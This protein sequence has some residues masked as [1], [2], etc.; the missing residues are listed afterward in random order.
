ML[1]RDALLYL[2]SLYNEMLEA[3]S[4]PFQWREYFVII[5]FMP[6]KR[7]DFRQI[8][9]ASNFLKILEKIVQRRLN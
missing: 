7:D 3:G 5:I 9:L 4:F 1:P 2:L 8:S 6:G